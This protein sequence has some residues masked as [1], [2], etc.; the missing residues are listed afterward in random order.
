MLLPPVQKICR[1]C[2]LEGMRSESAFP[3]WPCLQETAAEQPHLCIILISSLQKQWFWPE[4]NSVSHLHDQEVF[5]PA[6][7]SWLQPS[8]SQTKLTLAQVL[9]QNSTSRHTHACCTQRNK[10]HIPKQSRMRRM[11]PFR[12]MDREVAVFVVH[13][14]ISPWRG[15]GVLIPLPQE[16]RDQVGC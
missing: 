15:L 12:Q 2:Q 5:M 8:L 3:V 16:S 7:K 9:A 6:A 10:Q 1:S 13:D 14:C 11:F 4:P